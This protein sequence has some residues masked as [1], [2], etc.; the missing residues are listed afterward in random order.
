MLTSILCSAEE[1]LH[2]R[3]GYHKAINET[4]AIVIAMN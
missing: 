4:V 2:D 3:H 1:L